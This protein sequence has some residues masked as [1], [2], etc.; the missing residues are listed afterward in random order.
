MILRILACLACAFGCSI[1][2]FAQQPAL[3]PN[4]Q[5][6][7]DIFKQLI[8]IN[9]TDS[10][11][12]NVTTAAQAMAARLR[13]AGFPAEDIRVLGPAPNKQNLVARLHGRGQGK[14]I[15]F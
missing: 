2:S 15:L 10:P 13:A 5:L 9:T 1:G 11:A 12:G 8:E 6:A 4:Q 3:S 7:H 14:P